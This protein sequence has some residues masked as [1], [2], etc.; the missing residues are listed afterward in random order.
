MKE[1]SSSHSMYGYKTILCVQKSLHISN[2]ALH[3]AILNTCKIFILC[4]PSLS[5]IFVALPSNYQ[6]QQYIISFFA[7]TTKIYT[8]WNDI[9]MNQYPISWK[10]CIRFLTSRN[11]F[12]KNA[13]IFIFKY[14]WKHQRY[15]YME[16]SHMFIT[17]VLLMS[18]CQSNSL[19]K[20]HIFDINCPHNKWKQT[21][22]C[23]LCKSRVLNKT[24]EPS[25]IKHNPCLNLQWTIYE[26][27]VTLSCEFWR[28]S[29]F[30][31]EGA[32]PILLWPDMKRMLSKQPWLT[33][34]KI[35]EIRWS[36]P[37]LKR[38]LQAFLQ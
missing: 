10:N 35:F 32:P 18:S 12:R 27:L 36:P 37:S 4:N 21:E 29:H 11:V 38:K 17:K 13:A 7:S 30:M 9:K 3:I 1:K 2:S 34:P 20:C 25:T 28:A 16:F 15:Y 22:S 24:P 19:H 33:W 31:M 8:H 5:P 6:M 26:T 23:S 14:K